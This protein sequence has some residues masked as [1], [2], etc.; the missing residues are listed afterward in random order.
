MLSWG[1]VTFPVSAKALPPD[2]ILQVPVFQVALCIHDCPL[3]KELK[4]PSTGSAVSMFA[5][6]VGYSFSE[7]AFTHS[8][9]EHSYLTSKHLSCYC[10]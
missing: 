7:D 3:V 10:C 8:N 2:D 5:G 6:D 1:K 4:M 9:L